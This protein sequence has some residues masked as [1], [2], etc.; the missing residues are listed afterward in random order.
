MAR[1]DHLDE[2]L[3]DEYLDGFVDEA[4]RLE[5]GAHLL[6]SPIAATNWRS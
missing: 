4:G 1:M 5:I 2:E 3:L 6:V